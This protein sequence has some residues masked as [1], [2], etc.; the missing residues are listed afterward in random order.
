MID[1]VVIANQAAGEAVKELGT[2]TVARDRI[3]NSFIEC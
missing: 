3:V 1:G 2:T